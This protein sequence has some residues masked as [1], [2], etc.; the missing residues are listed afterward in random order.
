[1]CLKK[2]QLEHL[3]KKL[4]AKMISFSGFLM[5][6]Y[7]EGIVR[8]HNHVRNNVGVFDVS[9]M[10]QIFIEG[11]EATNLIQKVSSNDISLVETNGVQYSYLPN[12]K[13]GVIDDLLIYKFHI[14]KYMLVVN[15][16]NIKKDF[17]WIKSHNKFKANVMD[18]SNEFS[19]FSIQG[20]N[21]LKVLNKLLEC[22]LEKLDYYKFI[23]TKS[24]NN[25]NIGS[26]LQ[27]STMVEKLDKSNPVSIEIKGN[28]KMHG[29]RYL[30][31]WVIDA[32]KE[33]NTFFPPGEQ[34]LFIVRSKK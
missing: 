28:P 9:H 7:Y 34:T 29:L 8:E 3:H 32:M 15:A 20:P 19:L 27:F 13:G 25:K 23:N 31:L 17:E 21:S 24:I 10:G 4:N 16:S 1:M 26:V 14:N 11:K 22:N 5:P 2:I 33:G 30:P 18:L 6:L 12:Q